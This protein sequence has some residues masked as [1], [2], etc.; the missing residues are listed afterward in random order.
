MLPFLGVLIHLIA[1]GKSMASRD[2][3]QTQGADVAFKAC[4][5]T[6]PKAA[7]TPTAMEKT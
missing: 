7:A 3:E 5:R 6:P 4:M 2:I 1:R